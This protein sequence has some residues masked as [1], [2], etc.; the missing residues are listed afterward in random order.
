MLKGLTRLHT[1][2]LLHALAS[3]N[4]GDE[5]A[6][7]D[8]H[9]PAVSMAK[10]LIRLDGADL[11]EALEA[12]LRLMPLDTFVPDPALRME[13]VDDPQKIPE[14]QALCQSVIDKAEGRHV[15]LKGIERHAFY[16]RAKQAYGI[17]ATGEVRTYG[18][19]LIKKGVALPT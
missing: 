12:C 14:V 11:P 4:H 8:A 6:L 13:M 10:R 17:L 7:V 19:I 9:F 1:P 15:P 2:D 3:M 18:C 16:E 5:L